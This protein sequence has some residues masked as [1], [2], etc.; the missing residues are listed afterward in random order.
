MGIR[1]N[2]ATLPGIKQGRGGVRCLSVSK[3]TKV[4]GLWEAVVG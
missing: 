3:G 4:L 2:V 1:D